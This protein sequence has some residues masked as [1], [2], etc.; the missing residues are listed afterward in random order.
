MADKQQQTRKATDALLGEPPSK[1]PSTCASSADV[2]ICPPLILHVPHASTV[3]PDHALAD[4]LVPPSIIQSEHLRLVDWY[5]DELYMEDFPEARA[6]VA[7]ISRIVVD[8]ERFTD[9][10]LESSAQVG[11]GATYLKTTTGEELRR[12]SRERR[13]ALLAEYYHPHHARLDQLA[14]ACI[15]AQRRCVVLD[16]H[17]FPVKPLPTQTSFLDVSP[18]ICIGTDPQ[19]TCPELRDLVVAHFRSH[20][21]DVLL[22]KPFAG[23]LVPNAFYGRDTRVQ[24]VMIELRRDLYMDEA[25]GEKKKEG[26]ARIRTVLNELRSKL[27]QFASEGKCEAWGASCA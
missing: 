22:D 16:C 15:D 6:A 7:P 1:M 18:E 2:S 8:M 5:T 14:T 10:A 13:E 27:E 3:I 11:M 24:S 9:D 12:L 20:G 4:F 25:T 19:H 21:F 26:F 23:A 17:S